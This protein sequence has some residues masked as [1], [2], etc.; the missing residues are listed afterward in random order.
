[1]QVSQAVHERGHTLTRLVPVVL[2]RAAYAKIP[3][4]PVQLPEL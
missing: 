4:K 1:M 2:Y 3:G